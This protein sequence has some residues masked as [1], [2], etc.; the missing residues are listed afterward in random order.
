[1]MHLRS[2]LKSLRGQFQQFLSKQDE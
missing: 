2:E 1:V